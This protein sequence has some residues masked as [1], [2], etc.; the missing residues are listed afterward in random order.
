MAAKG[1]LKTVIYTL[2]EKGNEMNQVTAVLPSLMILSALPVVVALALLVPALGS[3][4][5][6]HV[7][8]T[9]RILWVS[10]ILLIPVVGPI[11]WF[12]VGSNNTKISQQSTG[13]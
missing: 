1:H 7:T 8:G 3:L 9:S 6:S 13:E 5:R 4:S 10:L 2:A 12:I 11:C